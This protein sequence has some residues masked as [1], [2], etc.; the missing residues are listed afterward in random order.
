VNDEA[1]R[2]RPLRRL[3]TGVWETRDGRFRFVS[4]IAYGAEGS[5]GRSWHVYEVVDGVIDEPYFYDRDATLGDA[6]WRVE[7]E[8]DLAR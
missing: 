3:G 5:N 6:A 4:G 7:R 8:Y 2:V 1:R